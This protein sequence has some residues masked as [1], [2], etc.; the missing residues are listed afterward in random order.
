LPRPIAKPR[1]LR[2]YVDPRDPQITANECPITLRVLGH[3]DGDLNRVTAAQNTFGR[4][5]YSRVAS[6]S[7]LS[8]AIA[9]EPGPQRGTAEGDTTFMSTHRHVDGVVAGVGA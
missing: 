6:H 8:V 9:E 2:R 1:S 3:F 7:P 5:T 4:K